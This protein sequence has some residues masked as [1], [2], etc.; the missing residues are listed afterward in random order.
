MPANPRAMSFAD[1]KTIAKPSELRKTRHHILPITNT[2]DESR[3]SRFWL[4]AAG[5]SGDW[6]RTAF[7]IVHAYRKAVCVR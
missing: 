6:G 5:A 1:G 3:R 2:E 7:S 4:F